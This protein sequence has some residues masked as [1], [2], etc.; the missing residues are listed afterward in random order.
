[1]DYEKRGPNTTIKT[2]Y[3]LELEAKVKELEDEIVEL[4]RGEDE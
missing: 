4:K 1:M 2:T 3:E